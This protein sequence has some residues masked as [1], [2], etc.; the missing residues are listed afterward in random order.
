MA[1]DPLERLKAALGRHV[2][3][4]LGMTLSEAGA[5]ESVAD[6]P[7]GPVARIVLGFTPIA[8]GSSAD[9]AA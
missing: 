8:V 4:N 9:S 3:P 5:V 1:P 2:E 6:G 7:G